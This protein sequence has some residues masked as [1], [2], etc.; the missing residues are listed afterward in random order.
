MS[1]FTLI[2]VFATLVCLGATLKCFKCTSE[3]S[4]DNPSSDE[5]K[6]DEK[7]CVSIAVPRIPAYYKGCAS[8][9]K[10]CD[11]KD[12]NGQKAYPECKVCDSDE[13]N[14]MKLT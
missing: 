5:C 1:K 6:E 4:C 10:I 12:S 7:Y 11:T 3:K 8:N 13:C 9:K 14:N 2:L